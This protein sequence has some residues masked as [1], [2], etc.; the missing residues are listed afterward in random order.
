M[1]VYWRLR[2]FGASFQKIKIAALMRLCHVVD[3]KLAIATGVLGLRLQTLR[4]L[5][6]LFASEIQPR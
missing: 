3:E 6:Q 2:S 1:L 5:G 4:N